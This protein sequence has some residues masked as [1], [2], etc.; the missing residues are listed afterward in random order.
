[1][2]SAHLNVQTVGMVE[3]TIAV[4]GEVIYGEE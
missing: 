2:A 3:I 4:N 1:M